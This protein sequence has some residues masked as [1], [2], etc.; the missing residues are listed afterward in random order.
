MPGK[1]FT[2]LVDLRCNSF[3]VFCGQR[4]VDEALVRARRRIG[5]SVPPTAFGD[6]RGRYTLETAVE[7]LRRARAEGFDELSLQGG[8][9]T[10]WPHVVPLVTDARALGFEF[11]GIVTNG[12]R[13]ADPAFARALIGAGLDAVTVSLVGHDAAS[14]DAISCAPGS[15]DELMAGIRNATAAAR[16]SRRRIT[17]NANVIT[18]AVTV[19]HLPD[20]VRLLASAGVQAANVH[21][22]RFPGLASDPLVRESLRF[23]I[24]RITAA[25][26]LARAEAERA[27]I[28]LHAT[29]VPMCLHPS[30]TASELERLSRRTSIAQH[31][32]QA[33]AYAFEAA[34]KPH[35]IPEQ[36]AGCILE[37]RCPRLPAEHLPDDPA[38]AL[39]PLTCESVGAAV[40]DMLAHMDPAA[41][42]AAARAG[43]R[44]R[45]IE[46]LESMTGAPG[47]LATVTA[48][49]RDALVDLTV[50]ADRRGDVDAMMTA[51]CACL[52][53]RAHRSSVEGHDPAVASMTAADLVRADG[54]ISPDRAEGAM[55][56]RFDPPFEIALLGSL[57]VGPGEVSVHE[58][59]PVLHEARTPAA[60]LLR[61]LFARYVCGP[62]RGARRLRVTRDRVEVDSGEGFR[63]AW[64]F[65][66]PEAA[67]M[68]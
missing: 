63:T 49:L 1:T 24:R 51:F 2:L 7:A 68:A 20:Q 62:L 47:A 31:R 23:D 12:R 55:R 59:R 5:L 26:A 39:R 4:E 38:L 22:V 30:L 65:V 37:D 14:H 53:L 32:F 48:T 43:D 27:G 10:I 29:D 17:L 21:L 25:L 50:L 54:A 19:D 41:P 61:A 46:L 16:E 9:P 66:R 13:L 3:C 67:V 57:R 58:V 60:R 34:D 40:S 36:C 64:T 56:L 33:A 8:E 45:S 6:T 18:S 28:A 44:L 52:G 11:V 42:G 15:F 35:G